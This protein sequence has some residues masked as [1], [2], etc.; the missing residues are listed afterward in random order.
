MCIRYIHVYMCIGINMN[1]I[2]ESLTDSWLGGGF[3]FWAA[4]KRLLVNRSPW[5]PGLE[6]DP[7]RGITPTK[8]K[9]KKK[10]P[11]TANYEKDF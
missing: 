10:D 3:K 9:Y 4:G 2:R 7:A 5:D 11:K 1:I 8:K 6:L